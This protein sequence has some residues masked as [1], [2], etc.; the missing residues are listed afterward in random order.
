MS[1]RPSILRAF[2]AV[3]WSFLGIRSDSGYNR[4][5]SQLSFRQVA[6]VGVICTL[7]FIAGLVGLVIFV[8]HTHG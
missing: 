6:V 7:L 3:F 4:D 1:G 8:T 5:I 2:V